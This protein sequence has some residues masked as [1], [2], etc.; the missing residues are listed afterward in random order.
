MLKW[1]AKNQEYFILDDGNIKLSKVEQSRQMNPETDATFKLRAFNGKSDFV[2]K[3]VSV[4]VF[5]SNVC[6][7]EIVSFGFKEKPVYIGDEVQLHWSSRYSRGAKLSCSDLDIDALLATVNGSIT[8][9]GV[10]KPIKFGRPDPV[11]F[12]LTVTD[13]AGQSISKAFTVTPKYRPAPPPP[14]PQQQTQPDPGTE[15]NPSKP[16]T[17]P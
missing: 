10:S 8:G 11:A 16:P 17:N 9:T 2:E 14:E 1:T 12:T 7:A 15:A 5:P 13:S 6:I 4:K 3:D